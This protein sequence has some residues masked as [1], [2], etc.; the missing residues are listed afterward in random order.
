[1]G[2]RVLVHH[3]MI[4]AQ[5]DEEAEQELNKAKEKAEEAAAAT[6]AA[7]A[8]A[9]AAPDDDEDDVSHDQYP[10][11]RVNKLRI[12]TSLAFPVL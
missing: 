1:M 4:S 10:S 7:A 8:A 9:K 5:A 2:S 11:P 3:W 12:H 6:T